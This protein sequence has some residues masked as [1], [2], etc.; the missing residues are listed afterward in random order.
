[1]DDGVILAIAAAFVMIAALSA[2]GFW[3]AIHALRMR[4]QPWIISETPSRIDRL[5]PLRDR[6]YAETG[7]LTI[8]FLEENADT[9]MRE[10]ETFFI[11][12]K[13]STFIFAIPISVWNNFPKSGNWVQI[14]NITWNAMP[15]SRRIPF[16]RSGRCYAQ[17][18]TKQEGTN[19]Q[20][21][22]KKYL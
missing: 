9:G 14:W 21:R 3:C 5:I 11:L 8:R 6:I 12:A 17:Q 19:K 22:K 2:F 15:I 1:M 18:E 7:W 10:T 4:R 13:I 20:C 16:F